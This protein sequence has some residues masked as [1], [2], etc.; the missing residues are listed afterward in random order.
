MIKRLGFDKAINV[1]SNRENL[2]E[3]QIEV[4]NQVENFGVDEVYFCTDDQN[5]YPAIFIKKVPRFDEANL[6]AIADIHRKIWN[7]KKILFLYVYNETEKRIYNCL[8]KL[9]FEHKNT[10]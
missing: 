5:S 10:N 1:S 7:Y 9:F 8:E 6:K 4:L 3:S 2:L